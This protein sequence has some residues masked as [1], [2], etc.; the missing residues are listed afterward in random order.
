M[1]KRAIVLLLVLLFSIVSMFV[2][3]SLFNGRYWIHST[4]LDLVLIALASRWVNKKA[5]EV[6]AERD[7][8][9]LSIS[10][11]PEYK[12]YYY[13]KRMS[14]TLLIAYIFMPLG[15]TFALTI[16]GEPLGYYFFIGPVAAMC[17][18]ILY[19]V[20]FK[21]LL[22]AYRNQPAFS[23]DK[24]EIDLKNGYTP[25]RWN[26]IET[27]TQ[28]QSVIC[29]K[30]NNLNNF[31][32]RQPLKKNTTW[33]N[34]TRKVNGYHFGISLRIIKNDGTNVFETIEDYFANGKDNFK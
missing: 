24:N 30:L 21:W 23:I 25:I 31:I 34:I 33:I 19:M 17:Y 5:A 15:F 27:I 2:F 29:I 9:K 1:K 3:Q 28:T 16:P 6:K 18:Y 10:F 4:V 26:E 32:D 14:V 22:P 12:E 8:E 13:S 11:T 20:I 7:I